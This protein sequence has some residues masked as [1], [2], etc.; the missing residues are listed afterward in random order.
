MNYG[1]VEHTA[2]TILE[3]ID[4][5]KGETQEQLPDYFKGMYD[6]CV[7]VMMEIDDESQGYNA[8]TVMISEESERLLNERNLN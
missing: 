7:A 1:L 6:M 3:M 5:E 2:N 4:R 8:V